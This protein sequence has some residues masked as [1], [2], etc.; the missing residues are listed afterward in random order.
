[1]LVCR[2]HTLVCQ[3]EGRSMSDQVAPQTTLGTMLRTHREAKRLTQNALGQ[4]C[5]LSPVYISQLEKRERTPSLHACR[6]LAGALSCPVEP[7]ALL[8][9]QT[10]V[11]QD[12]QAVVQHGSAAVAA[13]PVMQEC[14]PLLTALRLLHL[15]HEMVHLARE[16]ATPTL[17]APLIF[18]SLSIPQKYM[19]IAG[20]G[21]A[22]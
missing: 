11:P 21:H 17:G 13:D 22:S 10:T 2:P 1:M 4:R 8:V 6:A 18:L 20:A 3:R 19:T 16:A 5:Q 12:L 15:W 14:L 7:L 9:Y